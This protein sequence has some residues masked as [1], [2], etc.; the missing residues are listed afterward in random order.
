ME[1]FWI[2]RRW[3]V[4]CDSDWVSQNRCCKELIVENIMKNVYPVLKYLADVRFMLALR[5]SASQN[6]FTQNS[7]NNTF[8]L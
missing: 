5:A 1:I 3:C 8:F 4:A 2:Q 6:C 7:R